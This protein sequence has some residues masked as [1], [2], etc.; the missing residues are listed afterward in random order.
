MRKLSKKQERSLRMAELARRRW[1]NPQPSPQVTTAAAAASEPKK[2]T[3]QHG[4]RGVPDPVP[5]LDEP[6]L[7]HPPPRWGDTYTHDRIVDGRRRQFVHRM[8]WT[9]VPLGERERQWRLWLRGTQAGAGPRSIT[10]RRR[11]FILQDQGGRCLDPFG[12]CPMPDEAMA[13]FEIDHIV[14]WHVSPDSS[15]PNLQALCKHC[16]QIK[17][18]WEKEFEQAWDDEDG[19]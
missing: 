2:L 4:P 18:L 5:L 11:Q 13:V 14:P 6:R 17:T 16:H 19:W 7:R 10:G 15:R 3:G 1:D 12:V 8:Q 9:K